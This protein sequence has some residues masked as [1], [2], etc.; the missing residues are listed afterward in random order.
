M[1]FSITDGGG[2]LSDELQQH[3]E[4][5]ILFALSRYDSRVVQAEV[6]VA[7]ES[8]AN[9]DVANTCQVTV[10]LKRASLVSITARDADLARCISRAAE[11][12]GRAVGR[13]IDIAGRG[14]GNRMTPRRSS[15]VT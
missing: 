12:T 3:T 6:I 8:V 13:S 7:R 15:I 4:R 14:D 11:R 5:R 2:L 1:L 10:E 9:S